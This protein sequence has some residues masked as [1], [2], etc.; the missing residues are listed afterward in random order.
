MWYCVHFFFFKH[1][2]SYGMRISYCSS[3]LGS[4]EL[5]DPRFEALPDKRRELAA[6]AQ[7]PPYIVFADAVLREMVA[8]KPTSLAQMSNISG[9]GAKKLDAYGDAFLAVIRDNG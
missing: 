1:R 4:S 3:D 2:T 5:G 6:E 9:V 7:V 8:L